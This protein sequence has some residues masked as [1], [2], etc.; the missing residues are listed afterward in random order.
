MNGSGQGKQGG[1]VGAQLPAASSGR[2]RD[3]RGGFGWIGEQGERCRERRDGK[4][5]GSPYP[6]V[7]VV[8]VN[9]NGGELLTGSVTGALSSSVSI[10]VFVVDNGSTDGSVERLRA[11]CGRDRRLTIIENGANLGFTRASNIALRKAQGSFVLLLN[12]DC[13]IGPDTLERMLVVLEGH[14]EAGMA[15]CLIR[16][17]DGS[18]QAGCRRSVPTPWRTLVRVFHL[19]KLFPRSRRF[20]NFVL[21]KEPLPDQPVYV[22]AISGAFML[23]RREAVEQVGLLDEGYF[24]HCDD[25]DWC[26]RFGQKGWKILFV[27]GVE[28][29]HYQGTCSAGRP[30]FVLWH[31]HK[32]M[33][34]FYRRFFRHQYPL[35]LMVLVIGAVWARFAVLAAHAWVK[36][37][38]KRLRGFRA[39]RDS[40]QPAPVP[41]DSSQRAAD[42]GIRAG[43][44]RSRTAWST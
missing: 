1:V 27:P 3:R 41:A 15:G 36:L 39:P 38:M 28:V 34:R 35:P 32:G 11:A 12:P 40:R 18:E 24:L 2:E 30:V 42:I 13:V 26:M 22:E 29:T 7:S 19:D 25:L 9:F 37:A 20:R 16:N 23:I 10:E 17:E 21:T 8:V 6:T 43:V 31:K 14:P 44:C 4:E 33:V 5:T